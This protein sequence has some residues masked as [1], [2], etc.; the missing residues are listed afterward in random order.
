MFSPAAVAAVKV[1]LVVVKTVAAALITLRVGV[2]TE[3]V[4]AMEMAVAIEAEIVTATEI[5][6]GTGIVTGLCT[7][8]APRALTT[9]RTMVTMATA[10]APTSEVTATA[11]SPARAMRAAD[12]TMT[13]S[14]RTFTGRALPASS[15]FSAAEALTNWRIAT[16]S[17]VA[18]MKATGATECTGGVA[19]NRALEMSAVGY[20]AA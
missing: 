6:T 9:T 3:I 11:F 20:H 19:D 1:A 2:V 13:R 16:A 18:M 10:P 5:A 12:R 7:S 8:I 17:C 15:L 4:I 14:V